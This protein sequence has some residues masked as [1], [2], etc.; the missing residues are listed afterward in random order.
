[1][2]EKQEASTNIAKV[3]ESM[4]KT[5]PTQKAEQPGF[6]DKHGMDLAVGVLPTLIGAAF[7]GA[8]GGA[9][10]AQAG[11]KGLSML[12]ASRKEQ[13]KK[14]R[15]AQKEKAESERWEK[16][17]SLKQKNAISLEALRR[18]QAKSLKDKAAE[19]AK[20]VTFQDKVD[21]M[22]AEERK[23]LDSIRMGKK[24]VD[25][26][27][28]ALAKGSNTFSLVG[29]NPFTMAARDWS[30][31]IGRMQSGGAINKDE[32]AR[33]RAMAPSWDDSREIQAQKLQKL[34]EEMSRRVGTFGFTPTDVPEFNNPSVQVWLEGY[35]TDTPPQFIEK[36]LADQQNPLSQLVIRSS[37]RPV[38]QMTDEEIMQEQMMLDKFLQQGR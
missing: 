22:G 8:E 37:D 25:D 13:A 11:L 12:Q 14:E 32:E 1:M 18:A 3:A 26:M 10:G 24:A 28:V 36:A 21:K 23:R 7:Q 31:A 16:E 5:A 33:F 9:I 38:N 29:D 6:W 4:K 27:T 30:E 2:A 34:A 15:E 19:K 17:F 35:K 20:P